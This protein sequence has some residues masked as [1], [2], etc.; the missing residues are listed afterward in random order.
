MFDDLGRT[1][2]VCVRIDNS[3]YLFGQPDLVFP[4]PGAA[5]SADQ[6]GWPGGSA[7]DAARR[8]ART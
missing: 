7:R 1:N 4:K 5:A 8:W 6:A 2:N 3:D